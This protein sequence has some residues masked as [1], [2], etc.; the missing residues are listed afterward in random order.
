MSPLGVKTYRKI[1]SEIPYHQSIFVC[2]VF[3]VCFSSIFSAFVNLSVF[4]CFSLISFMLLA[5][6]VNILLFFIVFLGT[7]VLAMYGIIHGG[8]LKCSTAFYAVI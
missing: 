5:W 7:L 3:I 4:V 1:D 8:P 2:F 6:T